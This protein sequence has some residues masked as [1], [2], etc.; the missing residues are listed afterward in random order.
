MTATCDRR[1]PC[2]AILVA[3]ALTVGGCRTEGTCAT[4][5]DCD[6]LQVCANL[7][8]ISTAGCDYE[9]LVRHAC[10]DDSACP[11]DQVCDPVALGCHQF[12]RHCVA[13]CASSTECPAG[14][15]CQQG[16]CEAEPCGPGGFVCTG[17]AACVGPPIA[18]LEDNPF[19]GE[20][21]HGCRFQLCGSA[22][23]CR[24]PGSWHCVHEICQSVAG[25]CAYLG[26]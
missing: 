13:R 7:T 14:D 4:E 8:M 19:D 23:D 3:A 6:E 2:L 10:D 21:R 20:L 25:A 11:P 18:P 17:G 9:F 26:G 24:G 22:D 16:R 1:R 5:S 12:E 15:R